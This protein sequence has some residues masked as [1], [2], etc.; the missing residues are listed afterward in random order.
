MCR[1]PI[2][3]GPWAWLPAMDR[4]TGAPSP[5]LERSAGTAGVSLPRGRDSGLERFGP[6][7]ATHPWPEADGPAPG[8]PLKPGTGHG[9]PPCSPG[10]V[11]NTL[12]APEIGRTHIL[13][14]LTAT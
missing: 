8:E 11:E 2:V 13:T 1:P 3:K 10:S 4:T 14:P 5:R 6:G 9:T 7:R 12:P